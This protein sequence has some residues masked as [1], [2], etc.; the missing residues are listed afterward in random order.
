MTAL[1]NVLLVDDERL[2]TVALAAGLRRR[3]D[4]LTA[5]SGREALDLLSTGPEVAVVVSDMRMPAMSGAQ[6]LGEVRRGWPRTVRM[7]LTGFTDLDAAMAAVNEGNIFRFL[8][9]PCPPPLF[10]S[11]VEAGLAQHRLLNAERDLLEQTLKGAVDA[12]S[13][14]LELSNPAA[15]SAGR[16][17]RTLAVAMAGEL[18]LKSELWVLELA[19]LLGRLGAL[20]L[21][22]ETLLR[23]LAGAPLS[24]DERASV[25]RVPEVTHRLLAH[26]P[27]LEPVTEVLRLAEEGPSDS[28]LA[29]VLRVA[30]D[31]HRASARGLVFA[32]AFALLDHDKRCDRRAL[33]ALS[34]VQGLARRSSRVT[35][36]G[37][38]ALQPGMVL[39]D[40]VH[41]ASG[42]LLLVKG[43][44]L[45]D[46]VL[47]RLHNCARGA[48]VREP[49]R[50]WE[51]DREE[52]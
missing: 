34:R 44:L 24:E 4:V 26:V 31:Y 16:R 6:L 52:A 37:V 41:A 8:T 39:A 9:K 50:I 35:E 10:L 36:V 27:R 29:N 17:I 23:E 22:P 1:P 33:D 7:L 30:T 45:T 12:L 13:E 3:F 19:A 38:F 15:F 48:G 42:G 21:T 28:L 11:A 32:E 20:T 40:D 49:V 14:V 18:G 2:I 46:N 25:A 43:H 47:E 5:T 51:P